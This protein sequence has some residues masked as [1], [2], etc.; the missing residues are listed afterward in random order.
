M[1]SRNA[2]DFGLYRRENDRMPLTINEMK[3][4]ERLLENRLRAIY[5]PDCEYLLEKIKK[6]IEKAEAS[7][8]TQ[9]GE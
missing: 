3:L 6:R 2:N 7:A 1:Q 4:I 9:Q 8:V 5:D